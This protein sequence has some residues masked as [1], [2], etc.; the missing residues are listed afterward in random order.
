[1]PTYQYEALRQQDSSRT[2]GQIIAPDREVAIEQLISEGLTPL[3][4]EQ[5]REQR[6]V[7]D[8][9]AQIRPINQVALV[10]FS[11]Q[12]ATMI[13]SG[14]PV[15]QAMIALEE[16]EEN[17]KFRA[18]ITDIIADLEN[19]LPLHEAMSKHPEVFTPLYVAMVRSGEET[20]ALD[21]ALKEL[22]N[23]VEKTLR[24]QRAV[25]SATTYPK[26]TLVFAFLILSALMIF[27]VP[28]FANVFVET[29]QQTTPPGQPVPDAELPKPTQVALTISHLLYPETDTRDL[30]WVAQ[31]LL[32]FGVAAGLI[33]ALRLFIR[34]LLRE[35]RPRAAWDRFKL[36]APFR[37]GPI[38]Q[39]IAVARFARTFAALLR[40]GL[41]VARAMEIVADASG[42]YVVAQAIMRAREQLM[43][44][45]S[46]VAPLQR[47][48]IFPPMV[49]HMIAVG[50]E[51][52]RL[53]E[54]LTKVA[55]FYEDEVDQQIKA[56][57]S[58]IEPVMI[59][60]VASAVGAVVITIYLPMFRL[61][62]LIGTSAMLPLPFS[63]W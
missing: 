62:D 14:M 26:V 60:L 54:M 22:A 31:V 61:Y 37:I 20:G 42:N 34:R 25:K 36:N 9:I 12:L 49:T 27:M 29:V 2:S 24:I 11:R 32:R 57:S 63:V 51:T 48:A 59:F 28:K 4:V 43:A 5:I 41:P 19:G 16:T 38:V 1:M 15:L 33:F 17:P 56:M 8:L 47:A 3:V 10:A 58:L 55:E 30:G 53:E 13:D 21:Q 23:Q 39:K 50:E 6:N 35:E 45:S 7:E 18:V 40:S 44:G 46:I 52:G